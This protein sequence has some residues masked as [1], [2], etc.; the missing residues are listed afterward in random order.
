MAA[1]RLE[2]EA[3]RFGRTLIADPHHFNVE[4][5][6][7]PDPYLSDGL[8]PDPHLSEK[9]GIVRN[10]DAKIFFF[11]IIFISPKGGPAIFRFLTISR[12]KIGIP[13]IADFNKE[14]VPNPDPH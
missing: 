3:R 5:V 12:A 2:I 10:R 6:P 9:T 14:R 1:G 13:A 4:Q 11:L 8:D 7:N